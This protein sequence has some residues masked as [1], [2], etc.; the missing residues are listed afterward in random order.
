MESPDLIESSLCWPIHQQWLLYFLVMKPNGEDRPIGLLL[1]LI[2]VWEALRM[3]YIRAWC[4]KHQRE[5][6]WCNEGKAGEDAVWETLLAQEADGNLDDPHAW[7]TAARVLDLVKAFEKV[8]LLQVW[9][10]GLYWEF[11]SE[12]LA[13]ILTIFPSLGGLW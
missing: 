3:P 4:R 13:V 8:E 11:P 7:V 12:V 2:R 1:S 10:W 5:W 9:R 6:D